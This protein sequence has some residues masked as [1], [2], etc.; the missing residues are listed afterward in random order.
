MSHI[1]C[2]CSIYCRYQYYQQQ[3]PDEVTDEDPDLM[4][5]AVGPE[6]LYAGNYGDYWALSRWKW[7][8]WERKVRFDF[9][10]KIRN[11]SS[12]FLV[13]IRSAS[14]QVFTFIMPFLKHKSDWVCCV[15]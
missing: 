3:R 4:A 14:L 15:F 6:Q 12:F 10:W 8:Q 9:S 7:A 2:S 13:R 11:I 5:D 1:D